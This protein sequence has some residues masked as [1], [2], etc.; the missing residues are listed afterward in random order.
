[1]KKNVA[2][3]LGSGGARGVAHI[4]VINELIK[5]GYKITSIS[6]TS[7]GALVG[8]MH[9]SGELKIFENWMR[10]L[11]KHDVFKLVDFTLSLNGII[12]GNK[13]LKAMKNKVPDRK[14]EDL[15]ISFTCVATDIINGKEIVFK[16]GSLYDAIRASISIPSVF[17]PFLCFWWP[18]LLRAQ[19][20]Q[21]FSPATRVHSRE[22]AV[23]PSLYPKRGFNLRLSS[24]G[25]DS[26]SG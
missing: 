25:C 2:L 3:V 24:A 14:I 22:L 5:Q 6:G 20:H 16:R 17:M 8:G 4:G 19:Q 15:L 10:S 26:S 12:K 18:T 21:S 11:S 23:K 1:M 7:M 9:A 13:V